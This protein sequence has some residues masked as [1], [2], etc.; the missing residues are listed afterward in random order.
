MANPFPGMN[1]W[2]EHPSLWSDVHF[3]LI[4]SIARHQS[5]LLGSYYYVSIESFTPTA[6][7][8]TCLKVREAETGQVVTVI[9]IL[10]PTNKR[11]GVGRQKYRRKRLEILSTHTN[12]ANCECYVSRQQ[13]VHSSIRPFVHSQ[14]KRI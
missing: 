3:R 9:E 8:E 11:P 12:L 13:F 14:M 7:E 5:P 6:I 4:S 1:L 2:L 10:S